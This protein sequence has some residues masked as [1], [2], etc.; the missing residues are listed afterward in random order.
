MDKETSLKDHLDFIDEVRT[1]IYMGLNLDA[2]LEF[3]NF[4]LCV[5]KQQWVMHDLLVNGN[6]K[7]IKHVINN[8]S[9]ISSVNYTYP[10]VHNLLL[11]YRRNLELI[12]YFVEKYHLD[13][14]Y[15]CNYNG[16]NAIQHAISDNRDINLVKYLI[17]KGVDM[18]ST[19]DN[20][21]RPI[22]TSIYHNRFEIFKLLVNEGVNLEATYNKGKRPIHLA[23]KYGNQESINYLIS[24]NIQLDSTIK[25]LIVKNKILKETEK[26]DILELLIKQE[27]L[28]HFLKNDII[29]DISKKEI[30]KIIRNTT[31]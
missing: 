25:K 12:Q 28:S 14:N 15:K 3:T 2:L 31:Y 30:E 29:N 18:E 6:K 16:K 27:L 13:L 8:L 23:C 10:L 20:M 5:F 22:H 4:S 7:I 24:Q 26:L 19:D 9:C 17:D 21:W 1:I 11:S